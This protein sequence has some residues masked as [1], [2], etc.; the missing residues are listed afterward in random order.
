M[1]HTLLMLQLPTLIAAMSLKRQFIQTNHNKVPMKAKDGI[2]SRH[3]NE[4]HHLSLQSVD[5][6]EQWS[7]SNKR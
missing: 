2:Q 4:A 3:L 7:A 6:H 5:C 1:Q